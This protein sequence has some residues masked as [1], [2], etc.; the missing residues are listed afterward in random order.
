M[1]YWRNNAFQSL[2]EAASHASAFHAWHEYAQFCELL[3]KGLRKDALAHL[4]AF[5]KQAVNWPFS[6]KKEFISWLYH[7]IQ[8]RSD[9]FLLI[10]HPLYEEF[11]N[12][13]L[14][15]WTEREPEN[16]EPHRWLGTAEHL[17]EAI[18][19]NPADEIARGRLAETV[20]N[21]VEYSTH[22]LP[23]GY[24]GNANEDLQILSEVEAVINEISDDDKRS[25]YHRRVTELRESIDD[26][27]GKKTAT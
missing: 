7:F 1:Y 6:E 9:T 4:V 21:W 17:K 24:I 22:E 5:V 2:T 26:Y 10:P 13:T 25:R 15:E 23:Y 27:L 11:I 16:G 19:L 12:P 8:E 3:G 14:A 20:I 18:R